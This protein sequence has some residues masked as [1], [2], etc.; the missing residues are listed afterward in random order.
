MRTRAST[1]QA[2]MVESAAPLPPTQATRARIRHA[3]SARHEGLLVTQTYRV[4][5]HALCSLEYVNV[6]RLYKN[7]SSQYS[8]RRPSTNPERHNEGR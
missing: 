2:T 4:A 5:G 8:V 6:V 1:I 3:A 7:H